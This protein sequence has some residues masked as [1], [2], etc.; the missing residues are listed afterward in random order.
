V[1]NWELQNLW[2]SRRIVW[3]G[4]VV[5][6]RGRLPLVTD[7]NSATPTAWQNRGQRCFRFRS[8]LRVSPWS[9]N[10]HREIALGQW[11]YNPHVSSAIQPNDLKSSVVTYDVTIFNEGYIGSTKSKNLYQE[12]QEQWV[13][14]RNL[15]A[16]FFVDTITCG[17]SSF[18][19]LVTHKLLR[20]V[21]H[22][23]LLK[24]M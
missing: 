2:A 18:S 5:T 13:M 12:P 11:L 10:S 14:S 24:I 22:I 1:N 9:W 19:D 4:Q 3:R 8:C 7:A 23:S 16:L 17:T 20:R 6:E 21:W 15:P